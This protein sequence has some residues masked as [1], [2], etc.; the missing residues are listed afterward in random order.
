M[1]EYDDIDQ[2]DN[3]ATPAEPQ[4]EQG[5]QTP[6]RHKK[7]AEQIIR[8]IKDDKKHHDKAF[9]R[10]RRDMRVATWGAVSSWGDDNY[11]ANISGRHVKQKTAALYAKNPRAT[12]RRREQMDYAVWDENPASLQMAMQL[13]QMAQMAQAQ[14]A[15]DP[16]TGQPQID[17]M[18]GQPAVPQLP[19][20][21]EQAMALVEDFQQGY[22]RKQM[23]DKIGKTLEFLFAYFMAEQQPVDFKRGMKSCVRRALTTG[24][25]YVKLGFQREMGPRPGLVEQMGDVKARL[26]HLQR[27]MDEMAEGDIEAESAE[28]AELEF[29][30]TSLQQEP[31]I[32]LRE[33]LIVDF[34]QATKVIPD[35]L[36]KSLDGFIGARHLTV[37]YSYSPDEVKEIFGVD[38][39]EGYTAYRSGSGSSREISDNDVL[40]DDYEWSAPS[41]KKG[42]MVC[43]W[44][45]YD[46][47]TGLVYFVADGYAGFLREPAAPDVFVETFWPVYALTFNDVENEDEVFPPSDVTLMRDMQNEYNRSRQGLREHRDAARPRWVSATG[48]WSSEEDPMVIKNLKPFEMAS[49]NMDPSAKIQ[50]IMQ[51]LPVPGVDP[52]LYETGP[53]FTD[54]QLVVGSSEAQF[55]GVSKATATEASIAANATTAADGS[56]IDDLDAFLTQIARSSGQILQREMSEDIVRQIVGPGAVWPQMT[57]AEIAGEI[58]LEVAAGSTGKPNQAV[59]VNTMERL[60]PFLIQMPGIDP[61]SLAKEVLRRMDDRMDITSMIVASAPSIMAQNGMAQPSPSNPANDPNAQGGQ[62]GNNAPAAPGGPG[63]SDAA[64][65]SNQTAASV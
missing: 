17:P 15:V 6:D 47:A 34:P 33:G 37:E 57:L 1:D 27:L 60:L 13:V 36:T 28:A 53:I 56:G 24:V 62:G 64:F 26:D 51:S 31:E 58:Q 7:L 42:G 50:D 43:V 44:E 30:L 49:L 5:A 41:E 19:P 59:E 54:T 22:A 48:A 9:K 39:G 35:R 11:R 14:P 29:S 55:G 3:G 18:T 40:D 4:S 52:N 65:G 46:K 32:I 21:F 63:G 25:G 23:F 38:V 2:Q 8:S 45:H 20:G 61:V 16:V 10:M 12:A